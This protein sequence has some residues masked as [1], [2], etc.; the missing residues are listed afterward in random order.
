MSQLNAFIAR[1]FDPRDELRIRSVLDFLDTFQKVGFFCQ[2]AEAAEVESV[3]E[4][5]RRMIDEREVFIGFFTRRN[6]VYGSRSRMREAWGVLRQNRKVQSWTAPPWVLQESGYALRGD[7][8][9]ILLKEAGVE[10]PSL[11][12]DLEYVSFDTNNPAAV[13]S[14]LSE[15]IN[16]L[17]AEASGTKVN[18]IVTH[19]DEQTEVATEMPASQVPTEAPNETGEEPTF[20][21]LY[22]LMSYSANIHDL[23]AVA[24][25]WGKGNQLLVDKEHSRVEKVGW[26]SFY[27]EC[28]FEAGAT[29]ALEDLKR[30]RDKNPDRF[31]P[32]R[33]IA[34][35]YFETNEFDLAG[36]LF[37][38]VAASQDAG[39]PRSLLMA[40]KSFHKLTRYADAL[41]T[42]KAALP[43][44]SDEL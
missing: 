42:I 1:S 19:E 4:K 24:E 11:Q 8:K 38:E 22:L 18:I 40:A 12:G 41:E 3:S 23:N 33:S 6:P 13:F 10:L 9:L 20:D 5:V 7:R 30:L 37:L 43:I 21:D 25:A 17:L 29:D 28:R 36:P 15:M 26:D 14:K 34:R 16:G 35:C 32:N 27:F 39:K 2:T 44:I 31:E